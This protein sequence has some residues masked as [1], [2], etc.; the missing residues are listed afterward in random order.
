MSSDTDAA[1]R[2]DL[3]DLERRVMFDGDTER[4]FKNEYWDCKTPGQYRCRSCGTPLF[5]SS[6]KFDSGTGWPSFTKPVTAAAV[7][8]KVD[9]S[10]NMVR[11]EAVCANC[12]A[13]LGH[14]FPDG[15]EPTGQRY[16]MNSA[17]LKL[18][19]TSDE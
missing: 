18:S 7:A 17:S 11:T 15:P 19:P 16:C 8:E 12:Q 2:E 3:T 6:D 10:H 14:V 13:H 1:N 4:P 5:A 9:V